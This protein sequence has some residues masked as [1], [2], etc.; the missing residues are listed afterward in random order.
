MQPHF[1]LMEA[2]NLIAF[3]AQLEGPTP[4]LAAPPIPSD[5]SAIF[6]SPDMGAFDNCWQLWQKTGTNEYAVVIRGT[7][8]KPGSVIEDLLSV[9]IPA[10]GILPVGST[11]LPYKLADDPKAAVHLGFTLGLCILLYDP[12]N[13]ILA[14]LRDLPT[15]AAIFIAGHSQGAATATLCRSFLRYSPILTAKNFT[16]KTYLYAQAKPG[17]D[18]YGWDFERVTSNLDTGF[19]ISNMQ[20]W[21][22]QFPLTLQTLGTM[23]EPNPLDYITGNPVLSMLAKSLEALHEH[24]A[25]VHL[26]KHAPQF[27]VLE[28]ILQTQNFQPVAAPGAARLVIL[29]TLNFVGCGSPITLAGTPGT[30]PADPKD[31][32]WQHHAAM[33]YDL[34][35]QVFP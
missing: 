5:W 14:K 1:D 7:V 13:G 34:L 9:M 31:F 4:P 24:I 28:R 10:A 12:A 11:G 33:Y 35:G 15:G 20:D 30:N 18:H 16:Y 8:A 32:F 3:A 19:N 17:N 21:V 22:P 6:T 27:A 23:N 26:A 2:R 29:P 25:A